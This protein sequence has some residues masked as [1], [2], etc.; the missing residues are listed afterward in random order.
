MHNSCPKRNQNP[1]VNSATST[2][3]A[4]T[5]QHSTRS[6]TPPD[7]IPSLINYRGPSP[8]NYGHFPAAPPDTYPVPP[9]VPAVY[10]LNPPNV[11]QNIINL[12]FDLFS[13]PPP[14]ISDPA[15]LPNHRSSA[16]PAPPAKRKRKQK[17]PVVSLSDSLQGI[18]PVVSQQ[19]STTFSSPADISPAEPQSSVE[20]EHGES[21]N[22]TSPCWEHAYPLESN[23]VPTS[24]PVINGPL[25]RAKPKSPYVGCRICNQ[26][27]KDGNH[28]S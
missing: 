3:P 25:L 22:N 19:V 7:T 26:Q 8:V 10:D 9:H 27:S 11:S 14:P 2:P 15:V 12:D 4:Q 5:S 6:H 21:N 24:R 20:P 23:T 1:Q 17:T 13:L 16:A 18:G 28:P